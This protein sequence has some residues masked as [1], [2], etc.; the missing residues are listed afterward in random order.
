MIFWESLKQGALELLTNL[1]GIFWNCLQIGGV[2]F[3]TA[4]KLVA[5]PPSYMNNIYKI[6]YYRKRLPKTGSQSLF[7][8]TAL[9]R[10]AEKSLPALQ[11]PLD[12]LCLSFPVLAV[13][14]VSCKI[15]P[16]FLM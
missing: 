9:G 13:F 10:A 14:Y 2:F 15:T 8:S 6:Y 5:F 11:S 16:I 7:F 4:Y 12:G 1:G 3:G